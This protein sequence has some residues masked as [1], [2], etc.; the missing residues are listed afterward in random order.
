MK[1]SEAIERCING[2]RITRRDWNGKGMYIWF[3]P[4]HD[5]PI[6]D[7]RCRGGTDDPT[8]RERL[9]GVVR[10]AGHFDMMNAQDIRIIGWLA[11]QTDMSSD[12]WEVLE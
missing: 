6:S 3:V 1:F 9:N 12:Q 4:P 8:D 5:I 11:S 10:I 7:Y 2:A